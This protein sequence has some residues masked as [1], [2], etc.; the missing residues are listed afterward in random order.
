MLTL[1]R[2]LLGEI[3]SLCQ[4]TGNRYDGYSADEIEAALAGDDER[5]MAFLVSNELWGGMGSIA[6]QAGHS[7]RATRARIAELLIR[8]GGAQ[9]DAGVTNVR[10]ETWVRAFEK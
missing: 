4:S 3:M 10:T 1:A 8:L 6:D 5:L 7:D 9:I 2:Q